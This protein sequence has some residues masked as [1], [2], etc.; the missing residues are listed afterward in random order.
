LNR[1]FDGWID[2]FAPFAPMLSSHKA[3]Q[4][5]ALRPVRPLPEKA[6]E[7]LRGAATADPRR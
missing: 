2:G 1:R 5:A 3:H 4:A 6:G 7:T